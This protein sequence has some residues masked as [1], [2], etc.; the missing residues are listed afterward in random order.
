[1]ELFAARLRTRNHC[2]CDI[3]FCDITL[4]THSLPQLKRNP[5]AKPILA[6]W[7]I[8]IHTH[9]VIQSDLFIPYLDVTYP[10]KMGHLTLPER[11]RRIARQ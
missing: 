3:D 10:F 8:Y 11:S 1:M 9:L 4:A 5:S 7:I 2:Y 6:A